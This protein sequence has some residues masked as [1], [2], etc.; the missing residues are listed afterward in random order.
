MQVPGDFSETFRRPNRTQMSTAGQVWSQQRQR[1]SSG[2]VDEGAAGGRA[3]YTRRR[4]GT[5]SLVARN[6]ETSQRAAA[7]HG[8]EERQPV[9][10][11]GAVRHREEHRAQPVA[12]VFR[13]SGACW[14]QK[15]CAL[16]GDRTLGT[17]FTADRHLYTHWHTAIPTLSLMSIQYCPPIYT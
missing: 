2:S 5:R 14:L 12:D 16:C 6:S 9:R 1:P 10:G 3:H 17:A 13:Q 7:A 15:L 11:A 4:T 8:F